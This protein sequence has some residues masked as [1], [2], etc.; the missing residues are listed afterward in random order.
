VEDGLHAVPGRL[1][2][3]G[4]KPARA[5][6]FRAGRTAARDS[7]SV[8]SVTKAVVP[9]AVEGGPRALDAYRWIPVTG[10]GTF[11]VLVRRMRAALAAHGDGTAVG[12]EDGYP[13]AEAAAC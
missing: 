4:W 5:T 6:G 9:A 8:P 10:P 7:C 12:P 13:L 11:W 3:K 2:F 1:L